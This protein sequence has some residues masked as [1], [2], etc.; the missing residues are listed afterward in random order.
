MGNK[1]D[2]TSDRNVAYE[3]AKTVAEDN[4]YYEVSAK[5]GNNVSLAFEQLTYGI[6]EKENEEEDNPEKVIRGKEGRRT[7]DL[8]DINMMNKE[9]NRK[10][11]C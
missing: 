6:I 1:A 11:C 4:L 3:D 7:A 8:N 2:L 10:K 5:T 9:L